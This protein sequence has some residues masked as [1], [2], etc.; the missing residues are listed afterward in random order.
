MSWS[1]G[2]VG[3]ASAVR[4]EISKQFT[5]GGKC[6]E[7]EESIRQAAAS[8]IDKLDS[9]LTTHEYDDTNAPCIVVKLK[10]G[11]YCAAHTLDIEDLPHI[12]DFMGEFPKA[13][14][15]IRPA[16][17]VQNGGLTFACGCAGGASK[18][19]VERDEL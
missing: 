13:K 9:L 4:S 15:E 7:P 11:H 6:S 8:I 16:S 17:F 3:K 1:V 5:N 19:G 12:P 2:A 10:C 14:F 18:E